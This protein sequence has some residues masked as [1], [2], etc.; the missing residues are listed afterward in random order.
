MN[1]A[2]PDVII[3]KEMEMPI[4]ELLATGVWTEAFLDSIPN[5]AYRS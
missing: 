3:S 4:K 1:D 5:I 2:Y